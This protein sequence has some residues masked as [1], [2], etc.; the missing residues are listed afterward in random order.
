MGN[1][2]LHFAATASGLATK[3]ESES[4][5]EIQLQIIARLLGIHRRRKFAQ[6]FLEQLPDQYNLGLFLPPVQPPPLLGWH[7]LPEALWFQLNSNHSEYQLDLL[8]SEL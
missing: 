6:V 3:R 2:F 8:G 7:Y 5:A 1:R 4:V